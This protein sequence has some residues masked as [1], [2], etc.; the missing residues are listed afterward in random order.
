MIDKFQ[1]HYILT[2]KTFNY[3]YYLSVL[4]GLKTQ[5][6]S[7]VIV[8]TLEDINSAYLNILIRKHGVE[9]RKL[10]K[11][12]FLAL[13]G[14]DENFV[15]ANLKDYYCYKVLAEEGGICLDLDTI[16]IFDI[17][18][19]LGNKEMLIP[20][21]DDIVDSTI[22]HHNSSI[23]IAEK[24]SLPILD[25][26]E[27]SKSIFENVSSGAFADGTCGASVVSEIAVKHKDTV[28]IPK[29]RV[30]GG[31]G[32]REAY[33]GKIISTFFSDNTDFSLDFDIRIVHMFADTVDRMGNWC[34]GM[35]PQSIKNENSLLSRLI[36]QILSVEDWN[37]VFSEED[38]KIKGLEETPVA[39]NTV[40]L[41][42]FYK[43][44]DDLKLSDK[45]MVLVGKQAKEVTDLFSK[46]TK[47]LYVVDYDSYNT[48]K[49]GSIDFVYIIAPYN[50][51]EIENQIK[52]WLPKVKLDGAIAG[53]EYS[54]TIIKS[55]V[56]EALGKPDIVYK[57]NNKTWVKYK[58]PK[59]V[60]NSNRGRVPSSFRFHLL[61]LVH[62]PQSAEYMS[63]LSYDT[64]I[65]TKNGWE[66]IKELVNKRDGT[67]VATLNQ[68]T[69]QMEY[70]TPENYH[71]YS[72]KGN[73][74]NRVS[75]Q[76]DLLV[77]PDHMMWSRTTQ[78]IRKSRGFKLKRAD[79]LKKQ[80]HSQINLSYNETL[81]PE[82]FELP[83]CE[84]YGKIRPLKKYP[85]K[86]W[87]AFMGWYI[88]EGSVDW[89]TYKS[90]NT[91]EKRPYSVSI[92]QTIA[93]PVNQEEI[94]ILLDSLGMSY[95]FNQ[96]RGFVI[97]DVQLGTYLSAMGKS[98]E[99][100][101]P[102]EYKNLSSDYLKI[103][104]DSLIKG[105]GWQTHNKGMR[106]YTTSSA[107]LADDVQEIALKAG[108]Y[109]SLRKYGWSDNKHHH[110][111]SHRYIINIGE[112]KKI[113]RTTYNKQV[114][115]NNNV[116]C[117]TVPNS[118]I[119]VRRNGKCAWTGN[120]AFTQ[121]NRKL[122]KM[123]T[124]LGH[125][126]FFYGSEG[127]DVEEYCNSDKLHFVQTHTLQDIRDAWGS[128]DNRF[129]IGYDW[130]SIDFR[131]D[132]SGEKTPA[133]IKFYT[134]VIDYINSNKRPDDFLLNSMGYYYKGVD[135][136][137]NLFLSCESGI[138]YRGSYPG[139]NHF[140]AFE[141]AYMRDYTYGSEH[142]GQDLSGNHYDRVIP[143]YFDIDDFEFSPI[144]GDYYLYIG[145][146]IQRKGIEIAALA[147]NAI[148]K[149]LI[150]V[151]QGASVQ[152]N[153][154]LV[155]NKNPD[156]DLPP[157]T[158]EYQGF[159]NPEKRR[160]LLA[161][162][163]ATF[164]PTLY[165]E[166]FAGTHI[167]SMIS[168]T[169]P[170]C[171]NF[172]VFNGTIP[173]YVNGTIGFRCDTLQDFVDASLEAKHVYYQ[174]IRNYGLRYDMDNVKYDFQKWFE[175]LYHVYLS[176]TYEG[177]KGW[178]WLEG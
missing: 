78:D 13:K 130:H 170:I 132:F 5:K 155:P 15:A 168:G 67:E 91:E 70:Q 87:L 85:M 144:K 12:D 19:L 96:N 79:N 57:D 35:T 82:F 105:D 43:I 58:T 142:P 21:D 93:N 107:R 3:C 49:D 120:C 48:F 9:I 92:G 59:Q 40:P 171:T 25:A 102:L 147:C 23:L 176:T 64:D 159:A 46:S 126:V 2:G 134:K 11:V 128:G 34:A 90:L 164:V 6:V 51:D 32:W 50:S 166:P 7:N 86:E 74:I 98:N 72:Y 33:D 81:E 66:N 94:R 169:P 112:N 162:A 122:A 111:T 95:Y 119:F 141:S 123:L 175:D 101:I 31:F 106:R 137:V 39:R 76:V 22:Y 44:S 117:I 88:S 136:N 54:L 172:G 178:H 133:T 158:W 109:A 108:Y 138:G 73:L 139:N 167:E 125:E 121:K 173:D 151:G 71:E 65:L 156:F 17:T 83:E 150:I 38:T 20:L 30:C 27:M 149:K 29:F 177:E 89:G 116:Y 104:L 161:G 63:C 160:K 110:V 124:S 103:I 143:N 157:G 10:D 28:L 165:L 127:S 56:E 97:G 131:H 145:R 53:N 14:K 26:L 4:T 8:W 135:D 140:R 115:Y 42:I 41:E 68:K 60:G 47:A 152:E 99:K 80:E 62:L 163:I 75:Q 113:G 16:S 36:K 55:K 114:E 154:H 61:S 37:P 84:V 24:G 100:Y 118:T 153:G 18:E 148:N 1:L 146:M 52:F 174:D 129:E 45:Q 69:L 77:T